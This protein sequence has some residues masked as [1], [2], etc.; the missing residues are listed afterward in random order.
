MVIVDRLE[1]SLSTATDRSDLFDKLAKL[2]NDCGRIIKHWSVSWI[3]PTLHGLSDRFVKG[4]ELFLLLAE[5]DRCRPLAEA[6]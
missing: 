2:L 1:D 6:V 4:M 3:S 5:T